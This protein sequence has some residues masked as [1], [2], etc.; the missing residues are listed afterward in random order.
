VLVLL[1]GFLRRKGG[2]EA[3]GSRARSVED[4]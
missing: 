2:R 4:E 3:K 1:R